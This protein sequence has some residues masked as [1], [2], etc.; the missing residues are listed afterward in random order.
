MQVKNLISDYQMG[1][2]SGLEFLNKIQY[3]VQKTL[4]DASQHQIYLIYSGGEY[5]IIENGECFK[6]ETSIKITPFTLNP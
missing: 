3:L 6:L 5:F 2:I 4:S 1:L